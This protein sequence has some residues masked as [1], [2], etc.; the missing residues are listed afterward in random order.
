MKS[1]VLAMALMAALSVCAA[2]ADVSGIWKA[3]LPDPGDGVL[4]QLA[5]VLRHRGSILTGRMVGDGA[6]ISE[7]R[8]SGD[9]LSFAVVGPKGKAIFKGRLVN[10]ELHLVQNREG[11]DEHT[12]TLVFKRQPTG[13][14]R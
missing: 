3:V 12:R 1:V 11:D 5:V 2:G 4:R 9:I 8:I 13:A 10:G 14:G 6:P 7:G